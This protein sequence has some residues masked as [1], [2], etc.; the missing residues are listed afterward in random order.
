MRRRHR[1]SDRENLS[2]CM[3]VAILMRLRYPATWQL[4]V[5]RSWCYFPLL[6]L[7]SAVRSL[8]HGEIVTGLV[9][10]SRSQHIQLL[11][12]VDDLLLV[13]SRSLP[14]WACWWNGRADDD[15]S[16]TESSSAWHG[17]WTSQGDN[18]RYLRTTINFSTL[19][20][21]T[22]SIFTE[23]LRLPLWLRLPCD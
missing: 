18:A 1:W 7:F 5:W 23:D 4:Y 19:L 17:D 6:Y 2:P 3:E 9:G 16:A 12:S 21:R 11:S 15:V 13:C 14:L 20:R 10:L 8:P 22:W